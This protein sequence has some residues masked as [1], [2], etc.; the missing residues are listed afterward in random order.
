MLDIIGFLREFCGTESI[1][2]FER[3][4]HEKAKALIKPFFG[5]CAETSSGGLIFNRRC[6]DEAAPTL[7]FDTHLDDVGGVVTGIYEGGFLT[8]RSIGGLDARILPAADMLIFGRET[9]PGVIASTPPHLTSAEER[10][11][12]PQIGDL[13]IDTGYELAELEKIVGTGDP[14]AFRPRFGRLLGSA[15][16]GRSFDDKACAACVLRA[17]EYLSKNCDN[18]KWNIAYSLASGEEVGAG[19]AAVGTINVM[20][21]AA[22][23]LDVD[24]AAQPGVSG[25]G[26][27][28]LGDGP[29]I[30]ISGAT[31]R[32]LTD[33]LIEFARKK[34]RKFQT[35]VSAG[36]TGTNADEVNIAL[37]GVP[38]A[39]VS[40][41]LRNMHTYSE[42]I[43]TK[44]I[45]YTG[46]LLGEFIADPDGL[47]LWYKNA[48]EAML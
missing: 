8:F 6:A 26:A 18:L 42:V 10:G 2:G 48:K 7:M 22:F 20:P 24:F 1:S 4:A 17:M 39:V 12:L 21:D 36:G 38:T 19:G 29:M 32:P 31:D 33:A 16:V 45:E 40:L 27:G 46:D 23:V 30:A 9:I 37:E 35:V 5:D 25:S 47:G 13:L 3:R 11:K 41:P 44:D 28:K 14:V 34:E 15:V 43:D